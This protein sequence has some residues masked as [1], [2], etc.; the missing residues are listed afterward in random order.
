MSRKRTKSAADAPVGA[1][2]DDVVT[3]P[4]AAEASLRRHP[5]LLE[6]RWRLGETPLHFLA[7]EGLTDAVRQLVDWGADVNTV[8]DVN[9]TPLRDVVALGHEHIVEVLLAAGADPN[10]DNGTG[11]ILSRAKSDSVARRLRQAGAR[12][13]DWEQD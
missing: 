8:N 11:S 3:R 13:Q 5:E 4:E 6:A 10:A 12:L 2:I 1:F 9:T 7:V